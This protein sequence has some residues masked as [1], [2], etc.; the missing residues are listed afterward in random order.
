MGRPQ[1]EDKW[2]NVFDGASSDVSESVWA[3]IELD[4]ISNE[5][6]RNKNRVIFY[7]RLAAAIALFAIA[8]GSFLTYEKMVNDAEVELVQLDQTNQVEP[9]DL[10]KG[11]NS[12]S[13]QS[14]P[15][16]KN[17]ES[18]LHSNP[19]SQQS[20]ISSRILMSDDANNE[21]IYG[22]AEVD[23]RS[24]RRNGSGDFFHPLYPSVEI[25][26]KTKEFYKTNFPR[27]LPAMPAYMMASTSRKKNENETLFAS[28]GVAGGT[29]D[30]GTVAVSPSLKAFSAGGAGGDSFSLNNTQPQSSQATLGTAYSVGVNV[31]TQLSDRW[32]IQ[33]GI[34]Y[35]SQS[36]DYTTNYTSLSASNSLKAGLAEYADS[37]VTTIS[38]ANPYTVL[39]TNELFGI[40]IQIGF[41][42][43][44]RKF[45]I[46][47]NAGIS[48]DFF[49]KN[50]LTDESGQ[51][52]KFSQGAG[53]DSP[54]RNV[55]FSGL[56][57]IEFSYE[58]A[59]HSRIAFV[60]G[61]RYAFNSAL[62]DEVLVAYNPL[63]LDVGLRF[64]YVFQ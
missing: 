46:Q 19:T 13:R 38:Y 33:T 3:K 58:V 48:T 53:S 1:F 30:P 25:N 26:I 64:R 44:K 2:K 57:G 62:K 60:P 37:D 42:L 52:E 27:R 50:T 35:L 36:I 24:P 18:N 14:D 5:N 31:G 59:D 22:V 47:L 40:P 6:H 32:V 29:Y 51:L 7:Q 49:V 61:L 56:S 17:D 28:V 55:N 15:V 12:N 45:G 63:V 34:M 11:N 20:Q 23:R 4:L 54:Y 8:L 39:S 9:N 16:L 21:E 10:E 43:V 41:V